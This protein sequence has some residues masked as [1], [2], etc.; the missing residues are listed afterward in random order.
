MR[1]KDKDY[2]HIRINESLREQLKKE[3]E[4]KGMTLNAYVNLILSE[5]KKR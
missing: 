1:Y 4:E 3:A 2:I 5:R